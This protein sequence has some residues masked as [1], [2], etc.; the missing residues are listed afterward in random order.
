MSTQSSVDFADIIPSPLTVEN[1]S[2]YGDFPPPEEGVVTLV[3]P[4]KRESHENHG[5]GQLEASAISRGVDAVKHL[6]YRCPNAEI[7]PGYDQM[8]SFNQMFGSIQDV[9]RLQG[10]QEGHR[11]IP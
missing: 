4:Y 11:R 9:D 5:I 3:G 2:F 6:G 10:M 8:I 1:W 7:P